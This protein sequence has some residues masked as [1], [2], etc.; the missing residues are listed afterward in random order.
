MQT[1]RIN[2]FYLSGP[3]VNSVVDKDFIP[4]SLWDL[5]KYLPKW[6]LLPYFTL[7]QLQLLKTNFFKN[8]L[9]SLLLQHFF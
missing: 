8:Y 2:Q 4:H 1:I 7:T 9:F 5:I 6:S 3:E